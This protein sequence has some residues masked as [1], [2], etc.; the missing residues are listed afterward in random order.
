M[1]CNSIGPRTSEDR[2]TKDTPD[3]IEETGE[4][5]VNMVSLPLSNAIH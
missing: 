1:I 3:S 4:F 2:P 5:V